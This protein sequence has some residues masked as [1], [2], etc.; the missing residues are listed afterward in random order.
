MGASEFGQIEKGQKVCQICMSTPQ[1]L[2]YFLKELDLNCR[3]SRKA[4]K[5]LCFFIRIDVKI[6]NEHKHKK[7][8]TLLNSHSL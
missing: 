8:K 1:N 2:I 5:F 3:K 7:M 6:Q 4:S